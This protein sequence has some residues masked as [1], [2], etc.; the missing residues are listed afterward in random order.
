MNDYYK[1]LI[2]P[3]KKPSDILRKRKIQNFYIILINYKNLKIIKF[4]D[5][6]KYDV[7][8]ILNNH[9][10]FKKLKKFILKKILITPFF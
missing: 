4:D 9:D 3:K 1:D 2:L 8:I 10:I 7:Y 5:I 6:K